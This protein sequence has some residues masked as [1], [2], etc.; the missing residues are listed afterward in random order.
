MRNRGDRFASAYI[1]RSPLEERLG[2]SRIRARLMSG[3]S[4]RVLEV[5]A[6]QGHN[7]PQFE[8]PRVSH[9]W[10]LEPNAILRNAAEARLQELDLRKVSLVAG[11]GEAL[12]FVD[13]TFD[14]AVVTL[15]LCS[16]ERPVDVLSEIR[17][18]LKP[19]GRLFFYEHVASDN[20]IFAMAQSVAEPLWKYIAGNC[21]LTRDPV[22]LLSE[23][24]FRV[25]ES[26]HFWFSPRLTSCC[27]GPRVLGSATP[28]RDGSMRPQLG[29]DTTQ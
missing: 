28:D 23:A 15:V 16:V 10:A 21:H 2:G 4:G 18:V 11:R 3:L 8:S 27:T 6:G 26:E 5:G 9:V 13:G 14:S 17:R 12:P 1:R 7:F 25:T 22:A 20:Q 19:E 24:G 29:T